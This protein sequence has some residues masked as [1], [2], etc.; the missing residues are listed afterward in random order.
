MT[1]AVCWKLV[2]PLNPQA[3]QPLYL[4]LADELRGQIRRGEL[5][6]GERLPAERDL[7]EAWGTSR[8]T[9]R[10]ALAKLKTEGLVSS[11]PGRGTWVRKD[12]PVRFSSRRFAGRSPWDQ[13]TQQAG[14]AQDARL[15]AVKRER[16]DVELAAR[17][18]IEEGAE[19]VLRAS[20]GI[21]NGNVV[22][23]WKAWYPMTLAEGTE[24]LSPEKIADGIYAALDRIGQHPQEATDE[25][26]ARAATPEESAA[27]RLGQG[28][29]VL[30]ITRTTRNPEGSVIEVYETVASGE[31]NVF[32][33][34]NLPLD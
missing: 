24:L 20:E 19:V 23:L 5:V 33:Y 7:I 6:P 34:E 16:A 12:P 13:A 17:F 29:P 3:G 4:Q 9:I 8:T 22:Q 11:G 31:A 14:I 25:I 1:N 30:A 21:A 15:T 10:L 26:T 28:V 18:G 2:N 27:L 32:V